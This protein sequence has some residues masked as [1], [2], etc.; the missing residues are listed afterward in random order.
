[1]ALRRL[2]ADRHE[3]RF[4]RGRAARAEHGRARPRD[5]P[6]HA[7]VALLRCGRAKRVYLMDVRRL[8][9]ECAKAEHGM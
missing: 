7:R 3:I 9:V 5:P 1:M 2:G 8:D 6:D 4:L